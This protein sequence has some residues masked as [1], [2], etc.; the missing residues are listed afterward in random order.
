MLC[1]K[2][3]ENDNTVKR[4]HSRGKFGRIK[5]SLKVAFYQT[6][7]YVFKYQKF[8]CN[9]ALVYKNDSLSRVGIFNCLWI[10]TIAQRYSVKKVFLEILKNSQEDTCARVSFF[11]K[12]ATLLKKRLLHRCFP[13]NFSKFLRAPFLPEQLRW[14]LLKFKYIF[15]YNE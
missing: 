12:V 10:K 5:T 9:D 13:V 7:V 8:S 6:G 2:Q 15:F 11:N 3:P 1:Y 14:L 4:F